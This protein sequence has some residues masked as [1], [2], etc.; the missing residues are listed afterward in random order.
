[1][2]V[3]CK[4]MFIIAAVH[5]KNTVTYIFIER[6]VLCYFQSV[7]IRAQLLMSVVI[8]ATTAPSVLSL[9]LIDY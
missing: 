1:M 8:A 3:L 5:V 2:L 6:S 7:V 4:R 9:C